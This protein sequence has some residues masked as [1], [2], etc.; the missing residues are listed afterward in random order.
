MMLGKTTF[1]S[2]AVV[3]FFTAP[4]ALADTQTGLS[5]SAA[6]DLLN[7]LETLQQDVQ[8]L[9]G[10][11]EE[12]DHEIKLLKQRQRDRYIDL[13]KR[14]SLLMSSSM[15]K[16]EETPVVSSQPSAETSVTDVPQPPVEAPPVVSTPLSAPIALQAT[17]PQ[18]KEA[19]NNAYE[20]IRKKQFEAAEVTFS[21]F[22]KDYPDNAL[23]GNGY[24][25]LGELKL[26]LGKPKEALD[27]FQTVIQKFSGHN[28]EVDALYKLGIVNDQLG[29]ASAAKSYLQTVI[30]RFPTT[31]TA[32]LA[33]R[34]LENMK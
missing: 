33:S 20:L 21:Q 8:N 10:Q 14:I 7:Q 26:V 1:R 28:K 12:Q 15:Q 16:T 17:S 4:L 29:N 34:Y 30:Q 32:K 3:L 2:F 11:L 31:N 6:A 24:Y 23:T 13:D 18:A 22:V 9:R 19:Y 5:P 27:E 25:W